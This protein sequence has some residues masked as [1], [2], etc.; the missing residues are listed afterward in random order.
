LKS[1]YTKTSA[2]SRAA[3]TKLMLSLANG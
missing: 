2:D 3:L 1:I